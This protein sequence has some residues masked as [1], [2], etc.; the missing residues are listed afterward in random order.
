M[1][2]IIQIICICVMIAAIVLIATMGFKVGVKYS[3]NTQI[4]VNIGK[5]FD[6]KDINSITNE[7]FPKQNVIIQQVELYKDMVQITIKG[8]PTDEEIEQLNTKINEKYGI[9]NKTSDIVIS[10]NA[11]TKL[12]D[13][14]KPYIVPVIITFALIFVYVIIRFRKLGV[15]NVVY[16]TIVAILGPQALLFSIYAI[17]RIPI[18]RLTAVISG[19]FYIMSSV[20]IV[21]Y[22]LNTYKSEKKKEVV[23]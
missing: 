6:I 5:E 3:E 12:K 21:V 14:I 2:K 8:N 16:K 17:A 1:K 7:V 13:I 15:G 18:N 4:N 19:V 9:E 23:E 11:N 20:L 22:F 10:Q